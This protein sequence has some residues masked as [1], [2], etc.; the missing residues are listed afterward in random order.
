MHP[1]LK[2]LGGRDR[3]RCGDP[4]SVGGGGQCCSFL[5][6]LDI[7]DPMLCCRWHTD[8]GSFGSCQGELWFTYGLVVGAD[9]LALFRIR[10]RLG[11]ER[12][13][14]S[15]HDHQ[16]HCSTGH[17]YGRCSFDPRLGSEAQHRCSY[18]QIGLFISTYVFFVKEV[19]AEFGLFLQTYYSS[20]NSTSTASLA[21]ESQKICEIFAIVDASLM[22]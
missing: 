3:S 10:V 20:D 4:G 5:Y 11:K 17:F 6:C 21:S 8:L 16:H 12:A 18:M 22:G 15:V 1:I 7:R 19:P 2:F 13:V 9:R 14:Q